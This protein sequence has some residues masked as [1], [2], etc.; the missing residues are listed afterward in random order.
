MQFLGYT[1]ITNEGQCAHNGAVQLARCS[2]SSSTDANCKKSC[3]F[4]EYCIGYM[5]EAANSNC[6]LIPIGESCPFGFTFLP[7]TFAKSKHDLAA[8]F[9]P[10]YVCLVKNECNWTKN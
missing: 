9:K 4:L 3:N 5:H 1:V 6:L 10:G 7:G 8:E 2:S